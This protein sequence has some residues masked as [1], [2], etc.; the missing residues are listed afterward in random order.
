MLLH[1][2]T[3]WRVCTSLWLPLTGFWCFG[4]PQYLFAGASF[5]RFAVLG[6]QAVRQAL[7][8][9]LSRPRGRSPGAR[10]VAVSAARPFSRPR[11]RAVARGGRREAAGAS[12]LRGGLPRLE[13][14]LASFSLPLRRRLEGRC[15]ASVSFRRPGAPDFAFRPF[16]GQARGLTSPVFA[17]TFPCRSRMQCSAS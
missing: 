12:F 4:W 15:A 10:L 16:L 2:F 13:C 1:L 17:P 8:W 9:S 14:L 11:V 7:A 6:R 3:H 5:P